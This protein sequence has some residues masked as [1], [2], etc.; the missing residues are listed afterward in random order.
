MMNNVKAL[1]NA[2]LLSAIMGTSVVWGNAAFA[3]EDTRI[4]FRHDGSYSD[5]NSGRGI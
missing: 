4:L 3:A 2:I 5:K 1:G